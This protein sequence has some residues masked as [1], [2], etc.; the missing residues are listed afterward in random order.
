MNVTMNIFQG[1]DTRDES[2][3]TELALT[4]LRKISAELEKTLFQ[5]GVQGF[6]QHLKNV[7]IECRKES[8][9]QVLLSLIL[10]KAI[11]PWE[12]E[13]TFPAKLQDV[14]TRVRY[15]GNTLYDELQGIELCTATHFLGWII[16]WERYKGYPGG[17]A[18]LVKSDS[19]FKDDHDRQFS[20][21]PSWAWL[22]T[23]RNEPSSFT[24]RLIFHETLGRI[25]HLLFTYQSYDWGPGHSNTFTF[26]YLT[27]LYLHDFRVEPEVKGSMG[28]RVALPTDILDLSWDNLSTLRTLRIF[29]PHKSMNDVVEL[30]GVLH[31]FAH[32]SR[33]N[34]ETLVPYQTSLKELTV[35][36]LYDLHCRAPV[37]VDRI[38]LR[39][40]AKFSNLRYLGLHIASLLALRLPEDV[41]K[42]EDGAFR[43]HLDPFQALGPLKKLKQVFL[44]L[45]NFENQDEETWTRLFKT[46]DWWRQYLDY[47]RYRGQIC[48]FTLRMKRNEREKTRISNIGAL[49]APGMVYENE[50]YTFS[51]EERSLFRLALGTSPPPLFPFT[52]RQKEFEGFL[53][54]NNKKGKDPRLGRFG[55]LVKFELFD[56]DESA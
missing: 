27:H 55:C 33:T 26:A 18:E 36:T 30:L 40:L 6:K 28:N 29:A 10:P 53:G 50:L 43:V 22:G 23:R 13:K 41:G 16:L 25:T 2:L 32:I 39:G 48:Y 31:F 54:L 46:M 8:I 34:S 49:K 17:L 4:E 19:R 1:V 21:A 7:V 38:F 12:E 44:E 35:F 15:L 37:A 11:G 42:P 20:V 5:K 24:G 14:K 9:S 51:Q 56:R 45:Y 52:G 47:Y 3:A